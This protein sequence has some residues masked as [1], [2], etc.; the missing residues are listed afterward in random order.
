MQLRH[1]QMSSH[2]STTY[3]HPFCLLH[4]VFW[5]FKWQLTMLA[6]ISTCRYHTGNDDITKQ[7]YLAHTTY[8][9]QPLLQK[10]ASVSTYRH[11]QWSQ[12]KHWR[13][14]WP[15]TFWSQDQWHRGPAIDYRYTE[16]GVNSLSQFPF[17]EC[18]QTDKQKKMNALSHASGY[19]AGVG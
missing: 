15:L 7:A 1:C 8:A 2:L 16:F 14:V 17:I 12:Y 3:D 5:S 10:F 6:I 18:R 13:N 4:N 9:R 11:N 19:T